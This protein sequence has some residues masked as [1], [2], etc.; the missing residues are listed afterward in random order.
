MK[1]VQ[2]WQGVDHIKLKIKKKNSV[3]LTGLSEGE[4]SYFQNVFL[5][6]SSHVTKKLLLPGVKD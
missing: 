4:I 5:R 6:L 3:N 1:K 2:N